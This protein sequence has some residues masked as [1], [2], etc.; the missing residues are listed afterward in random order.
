[1]FIL[2]YLQQKFV[3]AVMYIQSVVVLCWKKVVMK[4]QAG[5]KCD[6]FGDTSCATD[7]VKIF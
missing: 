2:M 6:W 3:Q 1:M 7:G 5:L 4:Q